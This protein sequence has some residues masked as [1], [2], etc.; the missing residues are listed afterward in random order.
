MLPVGVDPPAVG[1]AALERPVVAGSDPDRQPSVAVQGEH[2]R[3]VLPRDVG[4][5]VGRAVIHDQHVGVRQLCVQGREHIRQVLL[6]VPRR[7]EDDGV[8]H[9]SR[10]NSARAARS[11]TGQAGSASSSQASAAG[12]LGTPATWNSV[13]TPFG[14]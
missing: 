6:L 1:I 11:C 5:P 14:S 7:D 10:A 13:V 9:P 12:V 2:R 4:R 3:A 8:A